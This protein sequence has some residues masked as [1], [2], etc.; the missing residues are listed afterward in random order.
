[1]T[2]AAVLVMLMLMGICWMG[3]IVEVEAYR[4]NFQLINNFLNLTHGPAIMTNDTNSYSTKRTGPFANSVLSVTSSQQKWD[5]M[6]VYFGAGG[7][8]AF[9]AKVDFS[10][11]TIGEA[12]LDGQ[13]YSVSLFD[14]KDVNIF[15][16]ADGGSGG[17][18]TSSSF[19]ALWKPFSSS[20]HFSYGVDFVFTNG[21]IKF[22][23]NCGNV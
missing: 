22:L 19:P 6:L 23:L 7:S 3:P 2:T 15:G 11:G 4:C 8:E 1:M 17:N 13:G 12:I 14:A 10:R 5:L 9:A 16:G 20:T 18:S 21:A